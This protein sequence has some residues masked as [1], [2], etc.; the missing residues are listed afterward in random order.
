MNNSIFERSEIDEIA[1]KYNVK[2]LSEASIAQ[3]VGI[4]QTIEERTKIPFIRMELGVPALTPSEIGRKAEIEAINKGLSGVYPPA[5]GIPE[6]KKE[7]SRFLKAFLDIELSANCCSPTTGS[8]GGMYAVLTTIS[9]AYTNKDTVLFLDPGFP[10]Q[11]LQ[12]KTVGLKQTN[13]DIYEYRGE[14]L[15]EK[16]DNVLSCGN[17]SAIIYSNPNN[18]AW[19]CLTELELQIIAECAEKW[20]AIVLEDLAYVCMDFR[21]DMSTP[22]KAPFQP[23]IAKYTDNY[24]ILVSSSK[25]FSYAGGRMAMVC[26][27]D[28]LYK[29]KYETFEQRY[30]IAEFGKVF[31]AI[32]LYSMCSGVTHTTQYA[33]WAMFKAA[34]DGVFN[35]VDECREYERRTKRMREI[36]EQNGFHIVYDKDCDRKVGDGFFFTLGYKN[37]TSGE[38]MQELLYYGISSISLSTT[39]CDK[40]G[41]RACSSFMNE[42]LFPILEQRAKLFNQNH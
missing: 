37:M 29:R 11:K 10:V 15:R 6:L 27:S 22:F 23:S 20:D 35:F 13:F 19:T 34:N 33:L 39:G 1:S 18:P 25:M 3:V 42:Q 32:I 26:I 16:L 5:A 24:I 31:N 14:K 30:S 38:L 7:T 17:I 8:I 40:Q 21:E 41:V 28:S 2:N 4:V 36:F 9:Q 12:A